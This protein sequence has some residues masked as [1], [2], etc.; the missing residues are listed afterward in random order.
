MPAPT[1][2]PSW[3]FPTLRVSPESQ[4]TCF[5]DPDSS[6]HQLNTHSSSQRVYFSPDQQLNSVVIWTRALYYL[7]FTP[8]WVHLPAVSL[9]KVGAVLVFHHSLLHLCSDS[10][11]A[12]TWSL[13]LQTTP[14]DRLFPVSCGG[15]SWSTVFPHKLSRKGVPWWIFDAFYA[16][17]PHS[18]PLQTSKTRKASSLQSHTLGSVKGLPCT[19]IKWIP[20]S[21]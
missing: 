7:S 5:R 14:A 20:Q 6:F 1:Y 4:T 12:M 16:S 11:G 3:L 10:F 21:I 13:S 2:S 19:Y 8:T 18:N 17:M 15:Y 9:Q